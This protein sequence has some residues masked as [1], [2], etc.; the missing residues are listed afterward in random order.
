MSAA[1]ERLRAELKRSTEGGGA[2]YVERHKAKGKLPP[3]ERIEALLDEGSYF[4][5]IAPLAGF[6][7][8][9]EVPGAGIIG[10]IG[11]VE[12]RECLI[13]AN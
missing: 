13:I 2:K 10:G 1:I 4:L 7:M 6:G 9:G 5:E 8:D 3:R 12:G 11:L